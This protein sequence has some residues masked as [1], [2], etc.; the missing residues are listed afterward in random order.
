MTG[1][2]GPLASAL[3]DN[4][5]SLTQREEALGHLASCEQCTQEVAAIRA[6]RTILSAS[7]VP[8]PSGELYSRL[9]L[10]AHQSRTETV[11]SGTA[12]P[13]PFKPQRFV[14]QPMEIIRGGYTPKSPMKLAGTVNHNGRSIW[15]RYLAAATAVA[16]CTGLYALGDRPTVTPHLEAA[17]LN[18]RIAGLPIEARATITYDYPI[19]LTETYGQLDLSTVS[20]L[21]TM[22]L[23]TG[24]IYIA[25][26]S[27]VHL[28][29]QSR[30]N[31]VELTGPVSVADIKGK[32]TG[33]TVTSSDQGMKDRMV[34]GLTQLAGVIP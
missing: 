29:W 23:G 4:Q 21:P 20:Q 8:T 9:M 22:D 25:S 10:F 12:Q 11:W 2:L 31:V 28:I 6:T 18:T 19:V 13:E 15:G 33:Y 30:E 27:P 32:L 16:V 26:S 24:Q 3:V 1:H 14:P 7:D 34:R 5:L 17:S